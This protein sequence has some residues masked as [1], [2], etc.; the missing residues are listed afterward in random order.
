MNSRHIDDIPVSFVVDIAK[1]YRDYK[2][3]KGLYDYTDMLLLAAIKDIEV[4]E[5]DYLFIDEAQDLSRL[6]WMIVDKLAGKAK[7]ILIA[8]DDKQ[9]INDFAGADV[10]TFL[11]IPG[12]VEALE[13]SY[14]VP[15]TIHSFSN[16]LMA[17]MRNYRKE[18]AFWKPRDEKGF[19]KSVYKLP[20]FKMFEESWLILVRSLHQM[21]PVKEELL[22][23]FKDIAIPFT[24]NEEPPID[25]DI[26]RVIDL[27][28]ERD[29]I[30]CKLENFVTI[31]EEDPPRV[32]KEKYDYIK[33]F[34]KFIA[35]DTDQK[36]QA[37]EIT[38]EFLNKLKMSWQQALDKVPWHIRLYA[39][40]LYPLYK[41]KGDAMFN[42]APIRIMTIHK[43]K[44]READNVVV[45][46]N[47]PKKVE[48]IIRL[49]ET[50]DELKVFYV[51][52]TRAKKGLYLFTKNA[53]QKY[54]FNYFLQ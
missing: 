42:D 45:L 46:M 5:L 1:R 33:L 54:S 39:H 52:V 35:C 47:V 4:P 20:I 19:V 41:E 22:Q 10:E 14:R 30:G 2:F 31:K 9:T 44:G 40:R 11:T 24:V 34:K 18:G 6:S 48:E 38:D 28:Q 13:Q 32:T 37:W 23:T 53:K 7:N 27:F 25:M 36:L 51:A 21:D 16:K 26:F 8:G 15:Q 3:M 49:N 43:A 29:S 50:D 17:K 12:R